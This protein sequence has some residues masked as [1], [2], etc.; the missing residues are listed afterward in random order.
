MVKLDDANLENALSGVGKKKTPS[1][2]EAPEMP[3]EEEIGFHKGS[4]TTLI[5]ERNELIS[6]NIQYLQYAFI[7]NSIR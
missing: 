7:K 5:N 4:L 2:A 3:K 6:I 1:K